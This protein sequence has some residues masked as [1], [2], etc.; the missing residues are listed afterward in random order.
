MKNLIDAVIGVIVAAAAGVI[1]IWQGLL[2]YNE[3]IKLPLVG[4]GV[5]GLLL[6]A[7]LGLSVR[8]TAWL[9]ILAAI[10]GVVALA[11]FNHIV[12]GEV[13]FSGREAVLYLLPFVIASSVS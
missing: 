13:V 1:S 5:F 10:L 4:G 8:I 3:A 9:P 2:I 6:G 11:G 7:F 12:Q